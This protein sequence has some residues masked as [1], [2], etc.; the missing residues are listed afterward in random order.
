MR[1]PRRFYLGEA[2][3]AN[4]YHVVTRT[5]GREILFGDEE[6]ERF[7]K[8]LL[9]QLKFSGLRCLSWCLMG[10]HI[11]LLVE[12]PDKEAELAGWTE[13][14]LFDRLA[15]LKGEYSTKLLLN[16]AQMFRNNGH[17]AGATE[18]ADRVRARLCDLSIFMKELKMKLTAAFN[19]MHERRGTLWE[20]RYKSTLV[21]GEDALRAVAAYIDLNPVRAGLVENPEDYRWCSY[22]TAVAGFK[23]ARSGLARAVT[24]KAGS[25]W[26]LVSKEYRKLLFGY[27]QQRL[28]GHTPEG[29]QKRKAGFSLERIEQVWQEGG[30]LPLAAALRCRV[31]YFTDGAVLGTKA[32]VDA[33]F[34]RQRDYFGPKRQSGARPMRGAQWGAIRSLRDLRV[35]PVSL[36]G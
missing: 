12:V 23:G 18:V 7:R 2:G 3:R 25:P 30:R 6:R 34:E 28:G 11:H 29:R 35:D 13:E 5:V 22:A 26:R 9:K 17:K 27:G 1:K 24:G 8:I 36:P 14:D 15:V 21:E 33:F 16:Q 4:V 19:A 10:N 20:G 31:R 32:S